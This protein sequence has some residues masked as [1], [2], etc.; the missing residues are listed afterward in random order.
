ME[1]ICHNFVSNSKLQALVE[2]LLLNMRYHNFIFSLTNPGFYGI[3][4]MKRGYYNFMSNSIVRC[5]YLKPEYW[6]D[7]ESFEM[8]RRSY[9]FVSNYY[10]PAFT[11]PWFFNSHIK[12]SCDNRVFK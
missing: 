2:S 7:L 10:S 6:A 11:V 3:F 5:R 8:E 1:R 12:P 4:D 9:N